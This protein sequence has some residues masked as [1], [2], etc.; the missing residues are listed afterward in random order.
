MAGTN[1]NIVEIV[2]RAGVIGAGGGGFPTWVKFRSKVDVVIA[3]GSECEPLLRSD[4]TEMERK[5]DDIVRGLMCAMNVTGAKRGVIALKHHRKDAINALSKAIPDDGSIKLHLLDN[6]YPAGDEFILVYEVTGKVIPE[7]GIP[8]SVGVLVNNV[9]TLIQVAD[10]VNGKPVIE[11][12]VTLQGEFNEPKVVTVPI[13][14]TYKELIKIAG[15][16]TRQDSVLLDGGPMMGKIVQNRE[17]GIGK[18]TSGIIALPPDHFIIRSISK[19]ISLSIKQ[20]RSACCQCLRCS[21]MCPRN[22]IGHTIYPHM[23]MRTVGYIEDLPLN[24]VTSAFLCSSCGVCELIA[25]DVMQ[26]SPRKIFA[27]YREKLIKNGIKNPHKNSPINAS[28]RFIDARLPLPMVMKKTNLEKY[29]IKI[30]FAGKAE[31]GFVRIPLKRHSG[32]PATPIV[33]KGDKVRMCDVIAQTPGDGPG[34]VCHASISGTITDI[35][36]DWI[37]IRS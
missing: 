5:P 31:V 24:Y 32:G 17:E 18:T 9:T 7:G 21:E 25:C 34:T 33:Q 4:L 1:T 16:F 27:A 8:L 35:T 11:R 10:A 23:T 36:S 15:G 20:A 28:E 37:E 14:T 3:N 19:P 12:N 29:D 2:K 22:L 6:Y 13:G 26:L 30:P